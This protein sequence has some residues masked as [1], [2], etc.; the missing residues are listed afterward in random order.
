MPCESLFF[1]CMVKQA[2]HSGGGSQVES[3]LTF[4][5]DS[6]VKQAVHPGGLVAIRIKSS[7]P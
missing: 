6:M 7:L 1:D 3:N 5:F 4:F 2:V